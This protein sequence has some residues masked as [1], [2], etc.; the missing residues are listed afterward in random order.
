MTWGSHGG[1]YEDGC[2]LGCSGV[3]TDMSLPAFQ[4]SVLPQS[5]QTH[6]GPH[7]ATTQ[8]TAIFGVKEFAYTC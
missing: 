3:Q 4:G 1:D 5:Y 8:K 2:L 7:G 6:T